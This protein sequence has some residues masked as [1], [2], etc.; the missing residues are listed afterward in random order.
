MTP[1][2]KKSDL[3]LWNDCQRK[4]TMLPRTVILTVA[5]LLVGTGLAGAQSP[6]EQKVQADR[7][8]VEGEGFWIYNDLPK[9]IAEARKTGKPMFVIM[10]CI[11]CEQCVKLDDDLV[12]Q[13]KRVRPLL[14]KFVCVRIISTNGL[15]L[16]LF[17]YDYDQSFAGFLLNAD[18]TIY[19]RFGTRSHRTSWSD[20]VSIEGLARALQGALD[21]H[22]QYPKNKA[23]LAGK[24]GPAP[25]V[26]SP[27]KYPLLRDRYKATLATEGQVVPSCI[28]CHQIGDAQRQLYRSKKEPIPEQVLFQYPHPKAVGLILDPKEEAT[29]LRAEKGTPAEQAGF[30]AGDKILKLEGQPLLSIADVQWVLHRADPQGAALKAQV[31]RGEEKVDLT[32][33][34]PKG[35]RQKDDISWRATSWGLRRMSLGGMLLKDLSAEDRGKAGLDGSGMALRIDYV[36]PAGSGGHGAAARAGFRKDDIIISWDNRTDLVRETDLLTYGVTHHKP[37]DQIPVI[38]LRGGKKTELTLTIQE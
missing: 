27:E 38:V 32:L 7:K 21:L 30:Q 37:G 11:P 5:A 26:P 15:D 3:T 25:D 16:S 12:N 6:R 36:A 31:Q 8:K 20:D 9:G 23:D 34:L 10:R 1:R 4:D 22:Q 29:I 17:Q 24:K 33:T 28:H 13:D 18:G 19:G 35:W 2:S 14:D